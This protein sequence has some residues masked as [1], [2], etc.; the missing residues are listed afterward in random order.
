[1]DKY[2]SHTLLSILLIISLLGCHSKEQYF[3]RQ[4]EQQHINIIRF[5]ES[6]MN[7]RNISSLD[8]IRLLYDE[9]NVFM[10]F[11]VN[12]IIGFSSSD[13]VELAEALPKFL[14]DTIYGF[15]ETNLYAQTEFAD[16][17][18]IQHD[19]DEAFTR[20]HYLFPDWE[21]PQVY[22]FL[23]GFNASVVFVDD[24][25]A[26]GIDMYLGSDYPYYNRVAYDYQKQTM[27]KQCIATDVVSAYLFSHIPYTSTKSRL[28]ENMIYRGKVMYLLYLL[29]PDQPGY[30]TMGYS[31]EQW[32][33]CLQYERAAWNRIMDKRD[34]FKTEN[35]V[36]TSYLN[37]GPFTQE[38]SQDSP[39]RM[40]TWIG[41]RIVESYMK[42][43]PEITLQQLMEEGDAQKI[44][45]ESY[46]KP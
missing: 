38:I 23:S 3:P 19:L 18:I 15:R 31:K 25:I 22:F 8:G 11:W 42:H 29:F 20:I 32:K 2:Y 41:W 28:L 46:Y 33:W 16:I 26:V 9:Y 10:P 37:D 4:M 6:L 5:D 30:E 13:T 7:I 27:R 34:L 45:E 35:M 21:M 14:E 39:G 1:M 24:D 44:L 43:N 12:H 36:L 40:G 17:S